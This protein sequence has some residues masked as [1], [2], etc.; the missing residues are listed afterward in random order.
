MLD[1]FAFSADSEVPMWSSE[2][3]VRG[4]CDCGDWDLLSGDSL[5]SMSLEAFGDKSKEVVVLDADSE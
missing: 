1:S 4:S 3:F 2:G 5:D